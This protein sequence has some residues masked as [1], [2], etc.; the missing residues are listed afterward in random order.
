MGIFDYFQEGLRIPPTKVWRGYEEQRRASLGIIAANTRTPDKVLG[1]LRAQRSALRVG[2][3][4]LVELAARYGRATIFAAMD[5]I[6]ARTE[7]S[8]RA[9]IRAIPDG[10]YP[11]E[12][13]LD[14]WG[15]GTDPLRVSVTVTVDGDTLDHRLRRARAPRRRR[16]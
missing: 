13:F 16:A 6:V 9:A 7:A 8:M 2:E 10:V 1:D 3:Q 14:D 12:D 5:E 15:P 4:R 11:F